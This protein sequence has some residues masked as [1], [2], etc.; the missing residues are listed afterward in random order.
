VFDSSIEVPVTIRNPEK[1]I[2]TH[3]FTAMAR[4]DT[5]IGRKRHAAEEIVAKLRQADVLMAQ[6]RPALFASVQG[7][8]V[9]IRWSEKVTHCAAS[10][11]PTTLAAKGTS[12]SILHQTPLRQQQSNG[13]K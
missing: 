2:G 12:L 10:R 7:V 9:V 1:R 13:N 4:N 11:Q 3:V 8:S 6:G 5:E